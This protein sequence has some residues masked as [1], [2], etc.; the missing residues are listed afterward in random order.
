MVKQYVRAMLNVKYRYRS[1]IKN[2]RVY[3]QYETFSE[4]IIIIIMITRK[5]TMKF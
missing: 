2:V 5:T 4:M 3:R 1:P